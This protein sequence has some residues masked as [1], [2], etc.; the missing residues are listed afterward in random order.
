MGVVVPFPVHARI[1]ST[2]AGCR[3][4]KAVRASALSPASTALSV[5]RTADHHSAGTLSRCHHLE[6]AEG[7]APISAAMASRERQRSIMDWKDGN[8]LMPEPI[9]QTV[10]KRKANLSLDCELSLGHNVPMAK[11]ILSDFEL[12]F[13]ARVY[14]ARETVDTQENFAPRLKSGMRQDGYKQFETRSVLPHEL[15]P[16]F[17]ELTKVGYEWL[18]TGKGD[19]PAWK[20]RYQVL[21]ERNRPK[22][23]KKTPRNLRTNS[24]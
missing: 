23:A 22:K 9:G 3:A 1:S 6:T 2:G 4:A 12:R 11:K 13:L 19:G 10:L 15:I 17:L 5:A 7:L 21:L 24:P 20:D 18:F 16:Q 8:W 14:A